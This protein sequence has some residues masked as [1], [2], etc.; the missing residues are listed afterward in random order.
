MNFYVQIG[1]VAIIGYTGAE[2]FASLAPFF[3]EACAAVGAEPTVQ[4][5]FLVSHWDDASG[6]TGGH[7]DSTTPAA[8]RGIIELEGCRQYHEKRMLKWVT[9]HTH[10]NALSPYTAEY[11]PEVAQAGLRVAGMGMD[12]SSDTCR[13]A[14]NGTN[15]PSCEAQPN[16]GFPIFDTTNG[17]LRILYFDT[18]DDDTYH[19]ALECVQ[20]KGWRGCERESFVSVWLDTPIIE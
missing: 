9:G 3:S 2:P 17:R 1:N 7:A 19:A 20:Q 18:H 10:C 16:F 13:V 8:F 5:V 12:A 14:N 4:V 6:V 15:C 11:G